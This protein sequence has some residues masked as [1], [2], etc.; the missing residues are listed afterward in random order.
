M[1]IMKGCLARM[2]CA[3]RKDTQ[4]ENARWK[5]G[6]APRS[7]HVKIR[8]N[9]RCLSPF[10]AGKASWHCADAERA[11]EERTVRSTLALRELCELLFKTDRGVN[12]SDRFDI[13]HTMTTAYGM[14]R[15]VN[16][17]VNKG[18][19]AVVNDGVNISPYTF[20]EP[21]RHRDTEKKE[22]FF[23]SVFSANSVVDFFRPVSGVNEVDVALAGC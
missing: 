18:V 8:G 23:C 14:S 10:P 7:Q 4:S 2:L 6:L 17:A 22:E 19:N 16:I 9:R 12:N 1:G 21:R 3:E 20:C 13:S 15:G 5:W 11:R